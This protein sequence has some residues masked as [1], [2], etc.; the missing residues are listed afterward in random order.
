MASPRP[1]PLQAFGRELADAG[2]WLRQY[3]R[4]GKS[5]D[6]SQA[7]DLYHRVF[8]HINKRLPKS[9]TLELQQVSPRLLRARDL[10]L[11]VP[12]TY[13]AGEEVV[14][15][16]NFWPKLQ[17]IN[18]KQRPRKI[19]MN[20]SDGGE[21]VF[22]L[23][24]RAVLHLPVGGRGAHPLWRGE[25]LRVLCFGLQPSPHLSLTVALLCRPHHLHH[26]Y[27]CLC[28]HRVTR[29]CVRTSG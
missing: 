21:Y 22:L 9:T 29:T 11:A 18:S 14:R 24:V 16:S 20:G 10:E 27:H 4:T 28:H 7:W 26:H 8:R 13:Q 3:Q 1:P 12:G 23:K 6:I 17:V 5:S 15:I 19:A 25:R 2:D